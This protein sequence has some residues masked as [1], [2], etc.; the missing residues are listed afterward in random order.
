MSNT[1]PAKLVDEWPWPN[2]YGYDEECYPNLYSL[3]ARHIS[4]NALYVF[5]ISD[6]KDDT[7]ALIGWV[8]WLH[9]HRS[10]M[11]GF[12]NVGYDYMLLHFIFMQIRTWGGLTGAQKSRLIYQYSSGLFK[13]PGEAEEAYRQRRY[14]IAIKAKDV[15]VPQID[16]YKIYHFDNDAKSTSLKALQINMRSNNVRDLPIKPGTVLNH[17]QRLQILS[18]NINDVDETIKFAKFSVDEIKLRM[19]LSEK[20]GIDMMNFSEG[21]VGEE[22]IRKQLIKA[23]LNVRGKT[24]RNSIALKDII[25]PYIKFERPEFQQLL[26]FLMG[27]VITKTKID[28]TGGDENDTE[29]YPCAVVDGFPWQFGKGGMHG[30]VLSTVVR[31]NDEYE[32][33]D[34]DVE[35]FYPRFS[36]VNGTYPAHL[37]PQFCTEYDGVFAMRREYPKGTMENLAFKYALNVPYGKSNSKF[38]FLYDPQYTMTTTINGQ[39]LLCMLGEW[40]LRIPGLSVIQA[41]TD[42]ITFKSPRV[43]RQTVYDICKYLEQYTCL[44]LEFAYYQAMYIRDVNNYVAHCVPD[45]KSPTGKIK[46]KGAYVHKEIPWH[47]DH[48][49]VIIARA[50]EGYLIR[51]EDVMQQIMACRDPFDFM[52]KAKV[53]RS[54]ILTLVTGDKVEQLQN[55]TRYY[56]AIN[57]GKMIKVMP[58]TATMIEN[59]KTGTHYV[60]QRDGDYKVVKPGGRRPAKTYDEVPAHL[61][62]PEPADRKIAIA[63]KW[64]VADCANVDD[65]NWNNLNY[66]YYYEEAMKLID[67]LFKQ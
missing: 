36:V 27:E 53:P 46:S 52:I 59:W 19:T 21:K 3:T 38:S 12:N 48:S 24:P 15:I 63:G 42:G 56:V 1:F 62:A 2:D 32:I 64:Y 61:I 6:W 13:Q 31:E 16:L 43:Y 65:F 23:G 5:E 9:Q 14:S 37:G 51:G 28:K 8:Y 41:N 22:I 67:P 30:S 20:F 26:N 57:G 17:D 49:S 58:P 47:K 11:L 34:V 55:T 66:G 44:K 54:S 45:E 35:S 50:V 40:L 7:E 39:L 18:Y 60:R 29:G 25:C 4:T 10:R 33:I